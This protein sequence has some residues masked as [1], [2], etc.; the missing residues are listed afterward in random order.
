MPTV[1]YWKDFEP[2]VTDTKITINAHST[3]EFINTLFKLNR[4][5]DIRTKEISG[6]FVNVDFREVEKELSVGF[7]FNF[8]V[9]SFEGCNFRQCEIINN[10]CKQEQVLMSE[11][12]CTDE[13]DNIY[14]K[15][16]MNKLKE[17]GLVPEV[18]A[19]NGKFVLQIK[20]ENNNSITSPIIFKEMEDK[21][22]FIDNIA[23][24]V[25]NIE[26][27]L[28]ASSEGVVKDT[29]SDIY[30]NDKKKL[31]GFYYGIEKS[32]SPLNEFGTSINFNSNEEAANFV[33]YLAN[34]AGKEI[35]E[36]EK[37]EEKSFWK[38]Q[39][40]N[41][42]LLSRIINLTDPATGE[43]V[44]SKED[45]Y[46]MLNNNR[47]SVAYSME[48]M[49]ENNCNRKINMID[50]AI[51][52]SNSVLYEMQEEQRKRDKRFFGLGYFI[53]R[54]VYVND[55]E[56]RQVKQ[57]E[58]ADNI[59]KMKKTKE[60]FLENQKPNIFFNQHKLNWTK[61]NEAVNREV[62]N[63]SPDLKQEQKTKERS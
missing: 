50:K 45:C 59:E 44:H 5:D 38:I 25:R 1:E 41:L 20:D 63:L 55:F 40:K 4:I 47:F 52:N 39:Q 42:L 32:K 36:A 11:T 46:T 30:N 22:V 62:K 15:L 43:K 24:R 8:G 10:P 13:F 60:K 34:E 31:M 48:K 27:K 54:I 6:H 33:K 19:Q 29:F 35:K 49:Y 12:C 2:E 26:E 16:P 23:R 53:D 9:A 3:E 7:P 61:H 56:K 14:K 57:N 37:D 18:M 21:D 51:N 58:I 17:N 28:L